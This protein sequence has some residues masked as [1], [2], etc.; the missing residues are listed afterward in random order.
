MLLNSVSSWQQVI[1]VSFTVFVN[2]NTTVAARP[3]IVFNAK[4]CHSFFSSPRLNSRFEG[5]LIAII[6]YG[7]DHI[8]FFSSFRT[9]LNSGLPMMLTFNFLSG[10]IEPTG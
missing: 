4:S 3:L 5:D 2:H 7:F 8:S 1:A 10:G 6:G 9:K